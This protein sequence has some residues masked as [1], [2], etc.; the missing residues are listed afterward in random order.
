MDPIKGWMTCKEVMEYLEVN[1][2][3]L[4]VI[5]HDCELTA[6]NQNLQ[7]VGS[8]Y[9]TPDSVYNMI[10]KY[11]E[12]EKNKKKK[13]DKSPQKKKKRPVEEDQLASSEPLIGEEVINLKTIIN[14]DSKLDEALPAAVAAG[15]FVSKQKFPVTK[16][17]LFK[18]L[19]NEGL[20]NITDNIFE[21]IWKAIPPEL[22][23]EG[24][25]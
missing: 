24:K 21:K 22:K 13:H 11:E 3:E 6:H 9:V 20:D 15:I 18:I 4:A 17:I 12:V 2:F 25:E 5:V 10:F 16:K 19:L 1:E 7:P 8:F 14:E 23:N